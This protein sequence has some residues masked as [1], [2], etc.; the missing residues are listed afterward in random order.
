MI[1]MLTI[2]ASAAILAQY[3]SMVATATIQQSVR[4]DGHD[5]NVPI[6]ES[7]PNLI[8][9]NTVRTEHML[10]NG[11]EVPAGVNF[12]TTYDYTGVT[13]TYTAT[14]KERSGSDAYA[15]DSQRL[16]ALQTGGIIT[17]N[18]LLAKDLQ[19]TVN[20]LS[21]PVGPAPIGGYAP[22]INI[23]LSDGKIIQAW[24]ADW[25]E[26]GLHTISFSTSGTIMGY[27]ATVNPTLG[28]ANAIDGGH[29]L[30][31]GP[32]PYY[33]SVASLLLDFG[34]QTV[35]HVEVRAQAGASAGQ[36]LRPTEFKAAGLTI[37]VPD[38]DT[39]TAVTLQPGEALP[40]YIC[41]TSDV[42]LTPG[43][44]TITTVV[45]PQH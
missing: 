12:D 43:T 31:N 28:Y 1:S 45:Q 18:G 36:V 5:Y 10:T 4:V 32:G 34:S 7:F 2:G 27:G 42:A 25:S 30:P 14:M 15:A 35:A 21:Q 11:A 3:G 9:G 37:L 22:N 26:T 20:V 33:T 29:A 24:G 44:Y 16:V 38:S 17:L 6:T 8:A 39:F 40:F 13:A 23:Y 41:Y 19:Y